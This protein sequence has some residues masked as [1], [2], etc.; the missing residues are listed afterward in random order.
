[1]NN[2]PFYKVSI[3]FGTLLNPE[4]WGM[5]AVPERLI[6]LGV[7][8]EFGNTLEVIGTEYSDINGLISPIPQMVPE[9]ELNKYVYSIS[10]DYYNF[11]ENPELLLFGEFGITRGVNNQTIRILPVKFDINSR[12]IRLY[13]K[14]VFRITYSNKGT[15]SNRSYDELLSS[16]LI[17]YDAAR[18]WQKE[19]K[20]LRKV[21]S[22]SKLAV[23]NWIK[24]E[25]EEEGIYKIDYNFLSSSGIDPSGL[26]PRTIKIYN[27]G[28]K[29]LPENID[30]PRP[31]DLVENAITIVGESD[32]S[33]DQG[34]YI[35]FYG[36]GANFWDFDPVAGEIIRFHHPYSEKNYFWLTY[37]GANGKRIENKTGLTSPAD[38]LQLSSVAFEDLEED[39][40][41]IGK[42]GREYF[43]D[44][45][46]QAIPSR[47][48]INPLNGRISSEPISYNFRFVNASEN[49][50]QL[51]LSENDF[52]IYSRNLAG[53]STSLYVVG[54]LHQGD[55][56]YNNDLPD[57]R[58]VLK[59]STIPSSVAGVGY[60]DYFEIRYRKDLR[61]FDDKLLFFS[62]D[63]SAII[64]YYLHDFTS[65]NIE[66]YDVSDY[67][68]IQL[69]TNPVLQSGGDYRFRTEETE[70][71]ISKY[72][73]V[74]NNN[75]L[76]P[77]N[78]VS[79]NNSNL[80]G[81]QDGAKYIIITS[82][83]F[84]SPANR[85]K[86]YRENLALVPISTIIINI[87]EI[88]N[89]FSAGIT[90]PTAIRDFVKYAYDNWTN[91]PE[92]LLLFGKGTYDA[93]NVT[94]YNDNFIPT[95]QTVESLRL[96]SSYTSDDYFVNVDGVDSRMDLAPGRLT[97]STESEA[98][99][100]VTKIIDYETNSKKSPWKNLITLVADD[101][102]HPQ[103]GGIRDESWEHTRPTENIANNIVPESFDL[104]KIYLAD[105]PYVITG[106]GRR[107][108]AVN[109]KIINSI[110]DGT[111]L[112]NFI[113]HGNPEVWTDEIVFERSST[114]SQLNNTEYFFLVAATC[115]FGYYD[116]PNFESAAEE[117]IFLPGAGAIGGLNSARL[118]FSGQN[119]NLN[120]TF[121]TYLLQ[122]PRDTLNLL[123][124][125][126][127]S[128]FLTRQDRN[129][130]NDRK[131]HLFA[132]P[133]LRLQV[134]R[135]EGNIDSINGLPL[136]ANVQI[137]ALSNTSI[138]GCILNSDS[139]VW[140]DY[141]GEGILTVFDSERIKLLEQIRNEPMVIPGG[142][143]F[144]GSISVVN[145][146]FN[147]QFVVPKDISYENKNGKA[148]FY[149]FNSDGDGVT[150]SKQLIIGGTDSTA[151]NDGD[152]PEI[153]IFFDD[154]TMRNAYLVGPQPNLIV[155]LSDETGL[156]TT[157]TGIGHRLEGIL[158]DDE[159][160]PIDFTNY[161]KSE[162]DAGGKAGQINYRFNRLD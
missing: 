97:F 122:S 41:N 20:G 84:M 1:I 61:V 13:S 50:I 102:F 2:R 140:E 125:V 133:L 40:I 52:D 11:E 71:S 87:D 127:R 131:Y 81:I 107:K 129:S 70:G 12:K 118:V 33:F 138:S 65:S 60:L 108:P 93:K 141:N 66:V 46:S 121:L 18:Y 136:I 42:T 85:L 111:L 112:V 80:R 9:G 14:I 56:T 37:G 103:A 126:G 5:P 73:A 78:P 8:S 55:A 106:G 110:N 92:Y 25:A 21:I 34:D 57:N 90:D 26:D 51:K 22:D 6:N 115:D 32:G 104:N 154:A 146:K 36:R 47:T 44:D 124:T 45:F 149:F 135:Y 49:P 160:A 43:G 145:G 95:W 130:T 64:E 120:Y 100:Y 162:L 117:L 16:A 69:I 3:A 29:V 132:D 89:E 159:S 119:H 48:Y 155:N 62:D 158:N 116:I 24:F 142:I 77:V 15:P 91:Q 157:G 19:R 72:F 17:N 63:T 152:G 128:Y 88:M 161:F 114:I 82:D 28:G 148:L 54:L 35:L 109:E 38:Y 74:G 139:L 156:N 27:N 143:I 96:L 75:Y 86:D 59:F 123:Q 10:K 31:I 58:S 147:T 151:V 68:N 23:G 30:E 137:K 134:P 153:E 79:V 53:Y 98:D 101:G 144:R 4:N 7:P 67:S 105:Y 99:N 150:F 113:G 83:E 39:K 94:G 76:T